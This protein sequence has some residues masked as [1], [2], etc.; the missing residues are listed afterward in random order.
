MTQPS[1][2][3]EGEPS[4][5]GCIPICESRG[6]LCADSSGATAHVASAKWTV[7]AD[8]INETELVKGFV[9]KA[10]KELLAQR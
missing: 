7:H 5:A 10:P 8:H 2:R 4:K 6:E 3:Y 1:P 9:A